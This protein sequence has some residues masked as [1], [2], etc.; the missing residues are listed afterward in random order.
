M[1]S[2]LIDLQKL[3]ED[4]AEAVARMDAAGREINRRV[5]VKA[6]VNNGQGNGF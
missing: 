3:R 6:L 4:R 1:V 5:D 2:V